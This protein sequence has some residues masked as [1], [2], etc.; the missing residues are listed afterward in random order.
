MA[1]EYPHVKFTGCNVV[2]TRHPYSDKVQFEVYNVAD[3]LHG[4]DNHYDLIHASGCYKMV[5]WFSL[6]HGLRALD[7]NSGFS[8]TRDFQFWLREMKRLLKPGG[9]LIIC[10]M[11]MAVWM[12][13]A[14]DP[15]FRIPTM[16]QYTDCVHSSLLSQG[17]DLTHMPFVGTWLREIG[18]FSIVDDT[19]TAVPVGAWEPDEL[20]KE[21]GAMARDNI[22]SALYSTH[23][24]WSR[25]G[26]TPQ[27][28]E[29]LAA[30]ARHELYDFNHE[31]FER[32]FY[33]FARKEGGILE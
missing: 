27:E 8:K 29:Q 9:I 22:M 33:V 25:L 31:M 23:P 14:S 3:G 28:I 26:K 24:L 7:V 4:K 18:G 15:W 16:C 17:I 11:E 1:V 13:D 19:V 20:Q 2:P 5:S 10:D 30:S 12:R 6:V 21:I 32:V